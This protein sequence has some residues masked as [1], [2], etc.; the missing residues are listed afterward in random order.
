MKKEHKI[1][2]LIIILAY[3]LRVLPY[4]LGYPIPITD[5][6]L[7]DFQQVKYLMEN[8]KINFYTHYGSFPILHLLVFG[9]SKLGFDVMRVFLFIPQIF[10]SL[11]IF[12]FFLFLK[13][14]FSLKKS[15][16]AC[17]LIAVFGPHIYWSSQPVRETIGLFFF[18]LI[19]YLFDKEIRDSKISTKILLFI[20]FI[21]MVLTHSW[22]TFMILGF[23]LFAVLFFYKDKLLYA[24]SLI[25]MFSILTLIYWYFFFPFVFR[26]IFA[27]L[28]FYFIGLISLLCY[29]CLLVFIRKFDLNRLKNNYWLGCTLILIVSF[30]LMFW[31]ILPFNY[32]FQILFMFILFSALVLIGFFCNKCEK[33][34]NF[35]KINFF[36]LIFLVIPIFYIFTNSPISKMPFDFLRISEFAIFP[37]SVIASYGFFTIN[38]KLKTRYL[39][40][41]SIVILS[42]L[43]TLTYPPIFI[44]KNNFE[45]TPFYDI[46]SDLRYIPPQGFELIE[47]AHNQGYSVRSNNYVINE[48]QNT[49]YPEKDKELLLIT[50]S[51]YKISENY[52]QIKDKVIGISNPRIL[53]EQSKQLKPIYS[54]EWGVLYQ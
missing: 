23:L 29:L 25:T 48:Y 34:N 44:Y 28:E 36:Y 10:A 7:R 40:P 11:G 18:P 32:P 24:L 52:H 5:D 21:L 46:R 6:S 33:M 35:F 37:C 43:A 42:F 31:G 4:F 19:I 49:F 47:W 30:F 26:L 51:D 22:S 17:F 53:I 1:I 12:F 16:F 45:N 39:L 54:N 15:L 9:I 14:Y 38:S 2:I 3:L 50:R 27:P 13:K 8:Q 20:S 41:F